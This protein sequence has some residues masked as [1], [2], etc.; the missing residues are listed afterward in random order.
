MF[1]VFQLLVFL[2]SI[3]I[4]EVSH[5]AMAYRLG[6]PTAKNMGR[7][8]FNPL[9]HLDLYGSVL[10]PLVIFSLSGGRFIFGSAKPVPYNPYNLRDKKFGNLKVAIAGPGSNF[11][12][13]LILGLV[14]RFFAGPIM[15]LSF[16]KIFISLIAF[17]VFVNLLLFLFNLLPFPPF[18]GSKIVYDLFPR[19]WASVMRM[20]LIGIFLGL[21]V[22]YLFL[23]PLT[24]LL[25]GLIV[26]Q[27]YF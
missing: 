19:Q 3:I 21:F 15:L 13:A 10:L 7:L 4:H 1:I 23:S 25:F 14:I 20:E 24:N 17:I 22:A 26:G 9:K 5:G 12:I 2:F 18:D 11:L 16:G 8:T 6:D 27:R